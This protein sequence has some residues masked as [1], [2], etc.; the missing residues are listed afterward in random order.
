MT[1][2]WKY[3]MDRSVTLGTLLY[4]ILEVIR[5]LCQPHEIVDLSLRIF[6]IVE[7]QA[8]AIRC[9]INSYIPGIHFALIF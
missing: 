5:G 1:L 6:G 3:R 7:M 8:Y 2:S 4:M 9:F